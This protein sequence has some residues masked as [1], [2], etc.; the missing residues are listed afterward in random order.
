MHTARILFAEKDNEEEWGFLLVDTVNA[1][2]AGNRVV[3][4]WTVRHLWS[5]GMRFSM[6]CY[7]HQALL[8]V[9]AD[10]EYTGHWLASCEGIT[11]D[12]PLEMILYGIGLLLLTKY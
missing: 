4:L 8:L 6:N 9:R 11:Q 3:Y 5:S 2:N 10:D 12:N 7:R 1:F